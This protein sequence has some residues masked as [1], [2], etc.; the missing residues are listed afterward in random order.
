MELYFILGAAIFAVSAAVSFATKSVSNNHFLAHLFLFPLVYLLS[1]L[2]LIDIPTHLLLAGVMAIAGYIAFYLKWC[3]GGVSR[4][5]IILGL[6][7]P[8]WAFLG[9]GLMY[10]GMAGGVAALLVIG[11]KTSDRVEYAAIIFACCCG[12]LV[13]QHQEL[14]NNTLKQVENTQNVSGPSLALRGLSKNSRTPN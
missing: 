13:Y 10:T 11:L 3:G 5:L 9:N 7:A 14:P 2:P 6:W 1:G 8:S 12:L 4:A